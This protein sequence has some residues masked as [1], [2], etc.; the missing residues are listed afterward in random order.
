M[1]QTRKK[2]NAEFKAKVA[3]AAIK[4]DVTVAELSS[5]F[6]VHASQIHAIAPSGLD[7]DAEAIVYRQP[8][9]KPACVPPASCCRNEGSPCRSIK[10]KGWNMIRRLWVALVMLPLFCGWQPAPSFGQS[11]VSASRDG[12]DATASPTLTD[13]AGAIQSVQARTD[14][15]QD[16]LAKA[17]R[18]IRTT[19]C[20]LYGLL[21][22]NGIMLA[23]AVLVIRG[24]IPWPVVTDADQPKLRELRALRR[25]QA[26]LATVIEELQIYADKTSEDRDNFSFLIK[27]SD[28][29]LKKLQKAT[30]EIPAA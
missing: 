3:L 1:K 5:R 7:R 14:A 19:T 18:H 12:G 8:D 30:A 26:K 20:L 21:L 27:S 16:R 25:Q 9:G 24:V 11:A 29:E 22:L 28:E 15:L 10:N 23:M 6:G 2:H 13:M 4:E 17:D